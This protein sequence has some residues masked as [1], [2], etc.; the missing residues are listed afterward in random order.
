HCPGLLPPAGESGRTSRRLRRALP[1]PVPHAIPPLPV[2]VPAIDPRVYDVLAEAG[3]SNDLFN[4]RQ[5]RGCEL[6]ELYVLHLAVELV[7]RLGVLDTL[8]HAAT[9]DQIVAAHGFQPGFA[10]PLSWLLDRL[11]LAGFV[12]RDASG[13]G[14]PSYRLSGTLPDTQLPELRAACLA[15]D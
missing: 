15:N 12:T 6:I 11:A 5:H 1:V 13:G 10:F 4:A 8:T 14:A 7:Q 3:Y 2:D 9:V